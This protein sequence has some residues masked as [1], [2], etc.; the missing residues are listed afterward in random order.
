[1]RFLMPEALGP[2]VLSARGQRS[3]QVTL[4]QSLV[5]TT[6]P[7]R[8]ATEL[9]PAALSSLSSPQTDAVAG[10]KQQA[11]SWPL[12]GTKSVGSGRSCGCSELPGGCGAVLAVLGWFLGRVVGFNHSVTN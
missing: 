3:C 12:L 7:R 8:A 1:M 9:L 10:E 4:W 2:T 5:L 6:W 11:L